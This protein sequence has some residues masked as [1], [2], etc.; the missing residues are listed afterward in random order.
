MKATIAV[1]LFVLLVGTVWYFNQLSNQSIDSD[2]SAALVYEAVE[3]TVSSSEQFQEE[4]IARI[5]LDLSDQEL[6]EVPA[7]LFEHTYVQELNLANNNLS[8]PL[9]TKL[10]RLDELVVLD[11]SNNQFT[12]IPIE[13]NQLTKL[14]E[15][16]LANNQL[17]GFPDELF[18]L[19]NL[20]I[21]DLSGN[22]YAEADLEVIRAGLPVP[23]EIKI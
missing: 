7:E 15:L 17:L 16:N 19:K 3:P 9:P 14:E 5:V 4:A 8:G 18:E 6:T 21:I 10:G 22:G 2:Q 11:L 23:V 12:T 1:M 20:Q 13:L